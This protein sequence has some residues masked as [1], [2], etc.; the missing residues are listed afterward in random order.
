MVFRHEGACGRG[1]THW[2]VKR[3]RATA[4]N[5]SDIAQAAELLEG[6][7][8]AVFA[9]AGYQ[10]IEKRPEIAAKCGEKTAFYVARKPSTLR[11]ETDEQGRAILVQI[12]KLKSQVRSLVEHPF[13]VI[14]RR[15]KYEKV[16][17]RGLAKNLAQLNTLFAL[18][19][20]VLAGR[21]LSCP[22]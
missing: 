8:T 2:F 12:E 15:F 10:G 22:C 3:V 14:K 13:Q 11:K 17:Y 21:K 5:V 1:C 18:A 9:D 20:L 6:E 19:N 4:A 7:E 16:R